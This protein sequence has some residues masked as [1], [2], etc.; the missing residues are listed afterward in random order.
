VSA[1]SSPSRL[2]E[3]AVLKGRLVRLEPLRRSHASD[4]A[5]ACAEDR[6]SYGFT[7]VPGPAEVEAF[8]DAGLARAADG[9]QA[10][11]AVVSRGAGRAVGHTAYWSPRPRPDGRGLSAVEVGSTW[12]AASAQGTGVN[13]EAKLLL[14]QHA[15]ATWGVARV[16]LTTDARNAR[17]RAAI[18]AVGATFEG[19]LRRWSASRAPGE[20]GLLRDTA[21]YSILAEEWPEVRD[22]LEAR[23]SR[24]V[25]ESPGTSVGATAITRL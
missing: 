9:V 14:F 20:E 15:F 19:V 24:G 18:E 4:L 1:A 23:V 21:V 7:A 3:A 8:V 6:G 13:A 10:P 2:P 22:R 12:L 11:Y 5:V 25:A 16:D 17:S